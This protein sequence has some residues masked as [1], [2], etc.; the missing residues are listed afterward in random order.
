MTLR[1]LFNLLL[2]VTAYSQVVITEINRDPFGG[3]TAIPGG[4]SHEFVEITNF[5]SDTFSI[6]SLYLTDGV[7]ID[8]V[9]AWPRPLEAHPDCITGSTLL[10]PGATALILDRNYDSAVGIAPSS[11]YDIRASTVLFT[12]EDSDLGNSLAGDDGVMIYKGTK[13]AVTRIVWC[14][15]D[16]P[17]TG[18]TPP[19]AKITLG[20]IAPKGISVVP[21][22]FLFDTVGYGVCAD[23]ITPGFFELLK[24]NWF[25]EWRFGEP[26]TNRLT[27]ACSLACI[28]A[29][30]LPMPPLSFRITKQSRTGTTTAAE[31]EC[32]LSGNRGSAAI[33]IPLDSAAY[34]LHLLEQGSETVRQ[35]DIS[36]IYTTRSPLRINEL[37]PRATPGEPEWIEVCNQSPMPI[38]I[39]NWTFGNSESYDTITAIDLVLA[40]GDFLVLASNGELF[41]Q[42]YPAKSRIVV[43]AHWHSLDNYNDTLCLWDA[44]HLPKETICYRSIWF[45]DWNFQSLERRT[46]SSPGIDQASWLPAASPTPGQPN[47]A[48]FLAAS[49]QPGLMTGPTPFT[50]NGDGR[51][52]LL[53]ITVEMGQASSASL[54]IYGFSGH[55]LRE[56]RAPLAHRLL[57]DGKQDNGSPAPTGPFIVVLETH[58]TKGVSYVRKK[59]VLW[60]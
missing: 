60:R 42:R 35:L 46:P 3:A 15:A 55:K 2:V 10:P 27:V 14:A 57:W 48:L 29:G 38:N 21:T 49:A 6:D 34:Y 51:D 20:A 19:K 11:R 1:P 30:T 22:S 18:T 24:S 37:F 54:A 36:Q 59:G 41:R 53:S 17:Y 33:T 8:A 52:D 7:E 56:F 47:G 12:T 43:P 25:A 16:S 39:K 50:P 26:D 45:T 44:K 40:P 58:S 9:V 23:S 13:T 32:S 4:A 31:G 5:G 28:K